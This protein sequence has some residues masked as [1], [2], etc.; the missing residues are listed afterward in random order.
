MF[1]FIQPGIS[2]TDMTRPLKP[3]D[4]NLVEEML[5]AGC[6]QEKVANA[7]GLHRDTL[8]DRF[9]KEYGLS[10]TE[11]SAQKR[12]YGEARLE[13]AQYQK[14]VNDQNVAML[15]HLGKVKLGQKE[16]TSEIIENPQAREQY[17]SLMSQLKE[18]QDRKIEDS[19]IS[20]ELKS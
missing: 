3:I 12:Q 20:S 11:Y 8:H 17:L 7:F 10:Y 4:W 13:H 18:F 5:E 6:T 19:N 15:I 16:A 9:I 14:A 2:S 1:S